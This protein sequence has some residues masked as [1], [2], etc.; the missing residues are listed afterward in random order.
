MH[1]I[2]YPVSIRSFVRPSVAPMEFDTMRQGVS[3]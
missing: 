3:E 2:L 1:Q